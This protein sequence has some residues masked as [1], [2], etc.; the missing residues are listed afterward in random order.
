MNGPHDIGGMQAFGA[1]AREVNEP[2]FHAPWE[3]RAFGMIVA[4]LASGR[5][6][7]EEHRFA[8][9]QLPPALYYGTTYYQRRLLTLE[10]NV[11]G[12]GIASAEEIRLRMAQ[13]AEGR[14]PSASRNPP[15]GKPADIFAGGAFSTRRELTTA[16]RFCPNQL[17]RTRNMHPRGHTRLARYLR[18]KEGQVVRVS[19][20]SVFPDTNAAGLGE[21]PQYIYSVRFPARTLWGE[22]AEAN[23]FVHA[24][25]WEDYLEAVT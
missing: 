24:D 17:V 3:G 15:S 9:E 10:A 11:I 2:V 7:G 13:L 18:D 22:S 4:L 23:T 1:I 8:M 21:Q 14:A 19:P 5:V 12:A 20:A 16:P 6:K 25:L